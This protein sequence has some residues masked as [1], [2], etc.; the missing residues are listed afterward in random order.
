MEQYDKYI[1]A[2]GLKELMK[3]LSN[4]KLERP[5]LL[6]DVVSA[7]EIPGDDNSDLTLAVEVIENLDDRIRELNDI[8]ERSVVYVS[9]QLKCV[10][11]GDKVYLESEDKTTISYRIVGTNEIGLCT[12]NDCMSVLSPIASAVMGRLIGDEVDIQLPTGDFVYK[13]KSIIK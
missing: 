10:E 2:L 9:K 12:T 1:T 6:D 8:V 11:F 4:L 13:I 5:V 3:I 7:R